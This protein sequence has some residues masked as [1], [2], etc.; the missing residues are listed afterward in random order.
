[1]AEPA[2]YDIPTTLSNVWVVLNNYSV[3]P[4]NTK[5]LDPAW[6]FLVGFIYSWLEMTGDQIQKFGWIKFWLDYDASF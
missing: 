3:T 1:M 6:I 4:Q 5:F 2:Q